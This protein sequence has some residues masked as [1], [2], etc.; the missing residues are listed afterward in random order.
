MRRSWRNCSAATGRETVPDDMDAVQEACDRLLEE[1]LAE[2]FRRR[3]MDA[4]SSASIDCEGCG[5]E[6]PIRRR[7]SIPG[8]SRCITCQTLYENG[9]VL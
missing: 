3:R 6:I 5:D 1:T 9:R 7:V 8:C 2:H 4:A